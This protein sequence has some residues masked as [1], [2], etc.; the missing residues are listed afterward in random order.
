MFI[1]NIKS[2]VKRGFE[3]ELG[4]CTLIIG[5]NRSGK[6]SVIDALSLALTG[7]AHS[8]GIGKREVDILAL[9]KDGVGPLTSEVTFD[10]GETAK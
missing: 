7:Y 8:D 1:K 2:N 3:H 9:A 6:S 4:P 10:S 5:E